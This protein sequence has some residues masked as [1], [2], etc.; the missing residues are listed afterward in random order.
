MSTI[1]ASKINIARTFRTINAD[2]AKQLP[3]RIEILKAGKWPS[4]SNKGELEIT[5]A[6][7]KEMKANFDS[8]VGMP[9]G[10]GFGLPVDF[11]HEDWNKAGAWIK[12]LEIEGSTLYADPVEWT[13]SGVEAV[14]GGEFK[15]ISP[16][17]Y[18]ACLGTWTDPEDGDVTAQNVL[19]GAGLTNIPFFK[20]LKP[21]KASRTSEEEGNEDKN[22][23]FVS[24][25]EKEKS[26]QLDEVRVKDV[27][28]LTEDEKSFLSEHKD[29]LTAEEQT[30][31]GMEAKAEPTEAEKKAEAEAAAAK[32][33]EEKA[34]AEAKAA[35]EAANVAL[36]EPVAATA[37][38]GQV[39]MAAEKVKELEE[40]RDKYVRAEVEKEVDTHIARGAIKADQRD[41]WTDRLVTAS[42]ADRESLTGLMAGLPSNELMAD[43]KGKD[44]GVDVE[45]TEQINKLANG[46]IEAAAK[47]GNKL[48]IGT[49]IEQV[50]SENS[51]LADQYTKEVG[52]K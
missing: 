38:P 24:A 9:G 39:V 10:A 40:F 15:C 4:S 26:M 49:A 22:L 34:A 28:S 47:V 23:I 50:L 35:E 13:P 21:I 7:L 43:A 37:K 20:D 1:E 3:T 17:F 46:K 51:V 2:N 44:T 14:Q 6:D 33:A 16:S 30:K 18:P 45:V 48:D 36:P 12:G 25:S 41:S 31:F 8:G 29:D 52:A 32:A 11:M 19:V 42:K 5:T 27:S